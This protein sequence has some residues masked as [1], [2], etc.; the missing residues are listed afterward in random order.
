VG[1][2]LR[3]PVAG[4]VFERRQ[5]GVLVQ[6]P[7]VLC[8]QAGDGARILPERADINDRVRGVVVDVRIRREIDVDADGPAFHGRGRA[9]RI[10]VVR[11][12]GGAHRHD[13]GERRRPHHAHPGAPLE[14]GRYQERQ[15]GS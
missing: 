10:G 8:H 1:I 15:P 2:G 7:H 6:T 4:E 5:H 13:L 12:A 9:D 3:V 11:I 14:V